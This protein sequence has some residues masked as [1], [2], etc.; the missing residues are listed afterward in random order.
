MR[1]KVERRGEG[2]EERK[3]SVSEGG[4]EAWSEWGE[5]RGEEEF[6]QRGERDNSVR[7]GRRERKNSVSEGRGIILSD[8]GEGRGRIRSAREEGRLG[9]SGEEREYYVREG[10]EGR[11]K[12]TRR[13][14]VED[15]LK[16]KEDPEKNCGGRG[17]GQ[18]RPG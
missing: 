8:L 9:Q 12:K 2:R 10:R 1:L 18:R 5:G 6:G 13:R 17:G 4:G 15:E 11:P 7:A 14:T 16:A 3:N